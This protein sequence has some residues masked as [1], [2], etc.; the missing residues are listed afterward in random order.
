MSS[1]RT[2][3][4]LCHAK[5]YFNRAT[6]YQDAREIR[7]TCTHNL[8]NSLVTNH[9]MDVPLTPSIIIELRYT[10]LILTVRAVTHELNL[11]QEFVT[12]RCTTS[13]SGLHFPYMMPFATL[14][15]HPQT[16]AH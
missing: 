1:P 8:L 9:K 7:V 11:L 13:I 6:F 14:A 3:V 12:E 4:N 15:G 5:I 2:Y 10:E 16:R